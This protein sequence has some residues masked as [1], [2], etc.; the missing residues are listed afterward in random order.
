MTQ[1]TIRIGGR[2]SK[3]AIVQ[4]EKV[5]ELIEEAFPEYDCPITSTHT[6]GDQIQFK[7]LYS[8]GGKALW[9][10]EL[11][12][13][14][15]H[16]DPELR[17]D[18]IV[19]SLKDMP[20]LLPDQFELGGI[21]KRVDAT[22]CIVMSKNVN[23][24]SLDELPDGALVGTSSVRRSAQ[25]KRKY[26]KLEFESVRGNI[27]TRIR[28]LDEADSRFA[29]IVLASAG[30]IR[31]HLDH[32]ITQKLDSSIMYSAVGQGALGIEIRKGD[33]RLLNILNEICDLESTVCCLA[34]R[35]LLRTLEGGCSVPIGVESKYDTT[36]KIL[37]LKA[38][39]TSV[40]G[41]RYV[42]SSHEMAI[43]DVKPDSMEC[44]R[45]LAEKLID[46]GAKE[47]LDEINLDKIK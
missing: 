10:K 6:L 17:L 34:E 29:C 22:D 36:T 1:E 4:S 21:T 32:R 12:D 2:R 30:L 43:N 9:T 3:L 45:I 44:G 38:I 27:L 23:Y 16:P 46:N 13:M 33:Q 47:I 40:E 42:E 14:L 35:A 37:V 20:T 18:L 19:H 11:E 8:F 39:V 25:L 26:P 31:M 15:Y 24:K 41:D 5:K 7:P 28:K